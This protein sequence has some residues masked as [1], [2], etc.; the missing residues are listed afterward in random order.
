MKEKIEKRIQELKESLVRLQNNA[1][2]HIGAIQE[3]ETLLKN[4]DVND[5]KEEISII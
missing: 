3:L 4:L 5:V 1:N 2:A